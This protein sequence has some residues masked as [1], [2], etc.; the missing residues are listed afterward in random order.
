[1]LQMKIKTGRR[2][3]VP[4]DLPS[5]LGA[6][7][8]YR[9]IGDMVEALITQMDMLAGDCDLEDCEGQTAIDWCGRLLPAAYV[10]ETQDD[11]RE[12]DDDAADMSWTEW[13]TRGRYKQTASGAE[14]E[15]FS[16][17]YGFQLHE[18]SE[19]DDAPEDDGDA[20]DGSGAEDEPVAAFAFYGTGPGCAIADAGGGDVLDEGEAP[21]GYY[22]TPVFGVDQSRGPI[23]DPYRETRDGMIATNDAIYAP[24]GR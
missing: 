1:M 9:E 19:Q 11:D 17:G 13:H 5:I 16:P 15:P 7:R 4:G 2:S 12:P 8:A 6:Q 23:N 21:D 20:E 24:A 10:P 22:C 3:V 18:D 14:Q